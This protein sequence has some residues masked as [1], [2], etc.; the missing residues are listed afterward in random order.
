[1]HLDLH[2]CML[3]AQR[4]AYFHINHHAITAHHNYYVDI[5]CAAPVKITIHN[6]VCSTSLSARSHKATIVIRTCVDANKKLSYHR[7]S[8]VRMI[9]PS[10]SDATDKPWNGHS[11]LLKVIHFCANRRGIYDF[12]LTLNSNLTSIFCRSWNI[13]PNLHPHP[14]CLPGGTGK[15]RLGIG[16][17]ALVPGCPEHWTIQS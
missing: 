11:R 15:R 9:L 8:A 14:T 17:H 13:T 3:V 2:T 10:I 16:R 5:V 7:D 1:M 12:L 6:S 4:P